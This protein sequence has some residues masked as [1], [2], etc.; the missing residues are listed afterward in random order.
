M[1]SFCAFS[2]KKSYLQSINFTNEDPAVQLTFTFPK[3]P[4]NTVEKGAKYA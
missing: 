1:A 2:I 4:I 3:L